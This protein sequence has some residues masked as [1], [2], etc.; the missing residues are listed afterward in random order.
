MEIEKA[1]RYIN[2]LGKES[3]F[4]KKAF[5]DEVCATITDFFNEKLIINETHLNFISF[6]NSLKD[7][8]D[9]NYYRAENMSAFYHAIAI[10]EDKGV[11]HIQKSYK[12]NTMEDYWEW[13]ESEYYR[14]IKKCDYI[15]DNAYD[16]EYFY[17]ENEEN[18]VF[19]TNKY[20]NFILSLVTNFYKEN[21]VK[22]YIYNDT[23][24]DF[25]MLLQLIDSE[26]NFDKIN[27]KEPYQ[28]AMS[29]IKDEE[30]NE[31]LNDEALKNYYSFR[32]EF[33]KKNN[34]DGFIINTNSKN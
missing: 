6:L 21:T 18:K 1:Y 13:R 3:I 34:I 14:N 32:Q 33:L 9:I 31:I 19:L 2:Y 17:K 27:A 7:E 12:E 4:L 28:W 30:N 25:L 16:D 5:Y 24:D 22:N 29:I 10:I 8:N 15:I 23:W 11:F 26:D 20:H